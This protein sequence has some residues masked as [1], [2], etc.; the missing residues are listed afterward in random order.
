MTLGSVWLFPGN[1][2]TTASPF[3]SFPLFSSLQPTL[4]PLSAPGNT[5]CYFPE[6]KPLQKYNILFVSDLFR[7]CS[8]IIATS[9][10]ALGQG[11]PALVKECVLVSDA[12]NR[13]EMCYV[14][15]DYLK[16]NIVRG[17]WDIGGLWCQGTT[18]P[19]LSQIRYASRVQKKSTCCQMHMWHVCSHT[20]R[21]AL[22][23]VFQWHW[24]R[25]LLFYLLNLFFQ[26]MFLPTSLQFR[27]IS[28]H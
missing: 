3:L 5:Q 25:F 21:L 16:M 27:I 14:R 6:I 17:Q 9:S 13:P 24:T 8:W 7:L 22:F 12:Q 28:R 19:P 23:F 26:I 2:K 1:K 4:F 15:V 18:P 11:F 10:T 20:L